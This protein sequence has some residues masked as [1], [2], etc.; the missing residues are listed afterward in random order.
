MSQLR[1]TMASMKSTRSESEDLISS[2]ALKQTRPELQ[3]LL[4][5][6]VNFIIR[7]GT[8]PECL[9]VAKV[10][11]IQKPSKDQHSSE[12]W[13]PINILSAISKL[14]EKV[15]LQQLLEH[16]RQNNLISHIHHGSVSHK[17]TQTL[18]SE[19]YDQLV[20]NLQSD[21]DTALVLLDQSKAYDLISHPILLKKLSALGIKGNAIKLLE[22]YLNQRKQYVQLQGFNSD[23][24]LIG[25]Q[26]VIQ[27][28]T[29]SCILYL[30]YIIDIQVVF[31]ERRHTPLEQRICKNTNIKTFVDDCPLIITKRDKP[32]L[33]EAIKES[34]D[35]I[36]E[37][38]SSNRLQLNKQ[39]TQIMVVT[40]SNQIREN[41]SI[42]LHNKVIKHQPT[43]K[44]LGN[45]FSEDL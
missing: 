22:S 44:V 23:K 36:E 43:A 27:G 12:G 31:H 1:R 5:H 17:S 7:Q 11:P 15:L 13:R 26:S 29:L 9:K 14:T 3:S 20:E 4:L 25:P 40:K 39:K 41:F 8:F 37:Y 32:T 45:L 2:W 18:V 35:L 33:Q 10:D 16:L 38:T 42:T 30:V 6:L 28:S 24:L 19:L 34:M 21:N